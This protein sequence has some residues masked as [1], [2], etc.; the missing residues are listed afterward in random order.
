MLDLVHFLVHV[1]FIKSGFM[2]VCSKLFQL[3]GE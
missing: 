2:F 3:E 1:L